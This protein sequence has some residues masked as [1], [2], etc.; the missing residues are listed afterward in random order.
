M[1]F[2]VNGLLIISIIIIINLL[3]LS[4]LLRCAFWLAFWS[5]WPSVTVLLFKVHL[6]V[7]YTS[8][9]PSM[10]HLTDAI[11]PTIYDVIIGADRLLPVFI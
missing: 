7:V 2:G 5:E 10:T 4:L 6:A 9:C 11:I 1:L 8:F 3:L